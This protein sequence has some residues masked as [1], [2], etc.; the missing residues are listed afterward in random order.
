[1]ILPCQFLSSLHSQIPIADEWRM[2]GHHQWF[3][4]SRALSHITILVFVT[5]S[6]SSWGGGA[7]GGGGGG[8]RRRRRRMLNLNWVV[9]HQ[10]NWAFRYACFPAMQSIYDWYKYSWR[11]LVPKFCSV[12]KKGQ[13]YAG[14]QVA[15]CQ[16]F[17][18]IITTYYLLQQNGSVWGLVWLYFVLRCAI[19]LVFGSLV[20]RYFL[21]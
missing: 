15:M 21:Y 9:Y 17:A 4:F 14:S 7:E 11:E 20:V 5:S 19:L 3:F 18:S 8:R 13:A 12:T 16:R 10:G 2:K 1:M 6:S